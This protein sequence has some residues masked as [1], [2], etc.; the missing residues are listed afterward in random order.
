MKAGRVTCGDMQMQSPRIAIAGQFPC[1]ESLQPSVF[2]L[3]SILCLQNSPYMYGQR[4][5]RRPSA[6]KRVVILR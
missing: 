3:Q 4:Y 2:R 6:Q 5:E 1:T